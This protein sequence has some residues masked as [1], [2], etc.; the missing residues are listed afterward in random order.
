[1]QIVFGINACL[2]GGDGT[3][4]VERERLSATVGVGGKE[5]TAN[6]VTARKTRAR[7]V[8]CANWFMLSIT[9]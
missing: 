2:R 8:A 6:V 1:M 9:Q 7:S 3:I 4:I 5:V